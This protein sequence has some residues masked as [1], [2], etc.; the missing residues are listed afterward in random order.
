VPAKQFTRAVL[1]RCVFAGHPKRAA[2]I[3]YACSIPTRPPF[4]SSV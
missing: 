1:N 2:I 4:C 3:E